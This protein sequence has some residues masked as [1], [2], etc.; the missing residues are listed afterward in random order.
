MATPNNDEE[1]GV[2]IVA[3]PQMTLSEKDLID[4]CQR[5][6][7]YFMVPRYIQFRGELPTTV[8]QK[9]E[10]FRLRADFERDLSSIW[11]REASGLVL[12]R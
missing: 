12:V 7:A 5:N 10:K 8:S 2:V 3:R 1:V 6:M 11:D 4:H 9:V